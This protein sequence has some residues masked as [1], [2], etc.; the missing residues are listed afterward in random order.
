MRGPWWSGIKLKF[1]QKKFSQKRKMGRARKKGKNWKTNEWDGEIYLFWKANLCIIK[2][3]ELWPIIDW[4]VKFKGSFPSSILNWSLPRPQCP[5]TDPLINVMP[6]SFI[7]ST[8]L[9][10]LWFCNK[11]TNHYTWSTMHIYH[12]VLPLITIHKNANNS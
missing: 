5:T 3:H 9:L 2:G 12:L 4:R 7:A 8:S 11:S 1:L 10:P 6:C